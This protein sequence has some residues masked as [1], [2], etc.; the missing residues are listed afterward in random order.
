MIS[1]CSVLTYPALGR[2]QI[3]RFDGTRDKVISFNLKPQGTPG[4][5]RY[6]PGEWLVMWRGL[7]RG[8]DFGARSTQAMR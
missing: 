8:S 2:L 7:G 5:I 6:S 4:N 1:R 3:G